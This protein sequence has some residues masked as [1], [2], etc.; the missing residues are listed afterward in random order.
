MQAKSQQSKRARLR[1]QGQMIIEATVSVSI[2]IVGLLGI[3]VLV[4]RSLNM[5]HTAAQGYVAANLAAEGIEVTKNILDTNILKGGVAWNYGFNDRSYY[6]IQYNSKDMAL[7]SGNPNNTL[8]YDSA[9]GL[10]SY[11]TGNKTVYKRTVVINNISQNEIQVN[12]IVTYTIN[13]GATLNV[14]V[15]DHFY[16]WK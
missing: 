9:T 14:N 10:Y 8:L 2:M 7:V 13:T 4:S 15:E 16:N 5:Y 1:R 11:D 12:S 6:G 3:F